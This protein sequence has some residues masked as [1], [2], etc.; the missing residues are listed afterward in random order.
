MGVQAGNSLETDKVAIWYLRGRKTMGKSSRIVDARGRRTGAGIRSSQLFARRRKDGSI[1]L[2]L[3]KV[4]D[5]I[6]VAG[7]KEDIEWFIS[8]MKGSRLVW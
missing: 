5:D 6:L 3:A 2:V 4:T 8:L 1:Q 7:N